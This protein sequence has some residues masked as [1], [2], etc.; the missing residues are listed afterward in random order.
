MSTPPLT[1]AVDAPIKAAE[2]PAAPMLK[3]APPGVGSGDSSITTA[4]DA[5]TS[6]VVALPP[7]ASAPAPA[8]QTE[9]SAAVAKKTI[10]IEKKGLFG[11]TSSKEYDLDTALAKKYI[12]PAQAVAQN[13]C[14]AAY[15]TARGHDN[16]KF[17][18]AGKR[19]D[20]AYDGD[21]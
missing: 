11:R 6:N 8:P 2:A 15:L 3:V 9:A 4:E 19:G 16:V 20:V 1:N 17:N 18:Y 10:T 13:H 7:V 14:T 5:S 21:L 12:T